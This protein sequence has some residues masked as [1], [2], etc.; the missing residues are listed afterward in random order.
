MYMV[1]LTSRI[2]SGDPKGFTYMDE[3]DFIHP[4][5]TDCAWFADDD[6]DSI[7]YCSEIAE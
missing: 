1:T 7:V 5:F 6:I 4:E 3:V 2:P